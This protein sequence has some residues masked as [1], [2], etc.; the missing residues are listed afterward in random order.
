MVVLFILAYIP[1]HL[2]VE[3]DFLSERLLP[4]WHLLLLIA[5]ATF[6]FCGQLVHLFKL[7]WLGTQLVLTILFKLFG[8]LESWAPVTSLSDF[9]LAVKM[10][11]LLALVTA[12]CSHLTL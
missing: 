8:V 6:Q 11:T 12:E 5:Q 7:D 10:A 2:N 4:D 3:V 9:K 1:T